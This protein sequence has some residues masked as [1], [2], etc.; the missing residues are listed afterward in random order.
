[1]LMSCLMYTCE[2][3]ESNRLWGYGL[4]GSADGKLL[5][6]EV[7]SWSQNRRTYAHH[8]CAFGDGDVHIFRHPHGKCVDLVAIFLEPIEQFPQHVELTALQG[9]GSREFRD[10]HQSA[11]FQA[12]QAHDMGCQLGQ[13]FRR[14]TAF[15]IFPAHVHLQADLQRRQRFRSVFRQA[16]GNFYSVHTMNPDE[17]F[18]DAFG[19]IALYRADEMPFNRQVGQGPAFLPALPAD[20][21]RQK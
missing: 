10:G 4:L 2:V 14:H 18:C 5:W 20:N 7:T 16:V 9:C 15:T 21:S 19:F 6:Y 11:Q 17:I 3:I 12:G 13:L 1:M 8:G